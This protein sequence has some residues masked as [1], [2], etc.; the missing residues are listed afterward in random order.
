MSS[1]A[2]SYWRKMMDRHGSISLFHHSH[3]VITCCGES[4]GPQGT[5]VRQGDSSEEAS[6]DESTICTTCAKGGGGSGFGIMGRWSAVRM[7]NLLRGGTEGKRS[8]VGP[9]W[10]ASWSVAGFGAGEGALCGEH[11]LAYHE[12]LEVYG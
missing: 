7:R 3:T 10:S 9:R 5:I 1:T 8:S 6:E 12:Y 11:N 4:S 2:A